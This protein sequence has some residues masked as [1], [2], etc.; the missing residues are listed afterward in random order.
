MTKNE[1]NIKGTHKKR[2][3]Y[4]CKLKIEQFKSIDNV[5]L[6]CHS[7]INGKKKLGNDRIFV[8]SFTHVRQEI[9][10]DFFLT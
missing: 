4:S 3:P 2:T 9:N 8:I 1:R 6:K 7:N 10:H 5:H